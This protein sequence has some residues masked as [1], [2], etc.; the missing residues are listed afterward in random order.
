MQLCGQI[1]HR[2]YLEVGGACLSERTILEF[3][4]INSRRI[5][6]RTASNRP[7]FEPSITIALHYGIQVSPHTRIGV[8]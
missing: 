7:R 5:S 2:N 4:W 8:A 6:A 3:A 1:I